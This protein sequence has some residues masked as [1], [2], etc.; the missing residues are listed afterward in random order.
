MARN[1]ILTLFFFIAVNAFAQNPEFSGR[2]YL[3][4]NKVALSDLERADAQS[5]NKIK[6]LGYG[7]IQTL[8][9][10]FTPK[11]YVRFNKSELPK[12]VIKV[13]PGVDP[14]EQYIIIKATVKKDKRTFMVGSY[15]M[16]GRTK[17][18]EDQQIKPEY[19]KLKDGVYEITLPENIEAGDY[20]FFSVS[21]DATQIGNRLKISCFGID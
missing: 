18:T 7:G 6:G 20:G 13:E 19:R 21:I 17:N 2:P 4:Q 3:W 12:L 11:S 16:T 14:S 10:V 15:S 1:I 5:D 9:T 8:Y